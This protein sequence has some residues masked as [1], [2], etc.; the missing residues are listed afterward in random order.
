MQALMHFRN[1][2]NTTEIHYKST[3]R[4]SET[5]TAGTDGQTTRGPAGS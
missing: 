2:D 1:G 4:R 5:A 3:A